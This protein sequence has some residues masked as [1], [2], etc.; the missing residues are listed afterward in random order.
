M[1]SIGTGA[2]APGYRCLTQLE[3]MRGGL[4]TL[5]AVCPGHR[6]AADWPNLKA[7]RGE[8]PR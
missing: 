1:N 6:R 5:I 4:A 8:A 3:R 2:L 7:L